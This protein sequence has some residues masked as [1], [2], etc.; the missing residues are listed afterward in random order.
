MR[1]R[2]RH[3]PRDPGHR[4]TQSPR[5]KPGDSAWQR[6]A[7][8]TPNDLDASDRIGLATGMAF[9]PGVPG[10]PPGLRGQG[11]RPLVLGFA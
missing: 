1:L 11:R 6:F 2:E 4:L 5:R 10:L 9:T 7:A 8:A 3:N